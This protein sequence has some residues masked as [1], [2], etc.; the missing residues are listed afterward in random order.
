MSY[1]N[2]SLIAR[3]LSAQNSDGDLSNSSESASDVLSPAQ[4]AENAPMTNELDSTINGQGPAINGE[5]VQGPRTIIPSKI[6]APKKKVAA[7]P[8]LSR[9]LPVQSSA[10]H[11]TVLLG[12]FS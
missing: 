4:A 5:V 9:P 10:Q 7:Q 12:A 2:S 8:K 11:A 6:L 3:L 1:K